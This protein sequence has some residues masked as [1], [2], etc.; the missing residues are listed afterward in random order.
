MTKEEFAKIV[1]ALK[2]Y[3]PS[4]NLI[5]NN[6]ALE[7][8]YMQLADIDYQAMSV[9]VNK[10]VATNKWSPTIAD[11]REQAKSVV[12]GDIPDWNSAYEEVRANIRRY[13]Y[14]EAEE[15]LK[16]LS[17]ITLE[18]VRSIGYTEMCLS[19]NRAAIRANFRDIYNRLAERKRQ[20]DALPIGLKNAIARVR[21]ERK[22]I[23]GGVNNDICD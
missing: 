18:T 9:A 1:A 7:L 5:P 10:W 13:G 6:Q 20:E 3:Y 16:H 4:Q 15:G 14:Y 2:T 19:E 21:E 8:W 12:S 11:L 22:M 23:E 17:D